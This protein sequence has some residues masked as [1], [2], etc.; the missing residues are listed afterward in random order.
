[1]AAKRKTVWL[2]LA[3]VLAVVL[4]VCALGAPMIMKAL[5]WKFG[6]DPA[7]AVLWGEHWGKVIRAVLLTV[8]PF[9][10]VICFVLERIGLNR[11]RRQRERFQPPEFAAQEERRAFYLNEL[12]SERRAAQGAPW[13][14][15]A[16]LCGLAVF[17]FGNE[18]LRAALPQEIEETK[19][20]LEM[21]QSGQPAVYEGPL[22]LVERQL[23]KGAR[24]IPDDRFVYYDSAGDSFRCAATLLSQT[25]LTQLSYT[26]TYLPET[27]TILTITDAAGAVRTSGMELDLAPPE[28]CWMYGDLAVPVCNQVEGYE[29]LSAGQQAL[30]DLMYSQVLS[31]DVAAGKQAVRSFDLPYPLKK[32]EYNAVVE[33]YEASIEPGQYPD[34]CYWTDDG[35]IVRRASCNR[36]IH[37]RQQ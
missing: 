33:L 37:T 16:A 28:G 22:L 18:V 21:Y 2:P 3:L 1:M 9:V 20:D 13:I 12:N 10:P 24:A 8:S 32:D 30:F 25:Q 17:L 6:S 31:G 7:V 29:A 23:R 26:V 36:I 34:H 35:R 11:T 5:F 19:R 15:Y 14:A 4:P 27:G